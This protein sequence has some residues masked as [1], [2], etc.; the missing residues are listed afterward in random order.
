[1]KNLTN[2]IE[3]TT[4]VKG[5]EICEGVIISSDFKT[6]EALLLFFNKEVSGE[7]AEICYIKRRKGA[8]NWEYWSQTN[9]SYKVYDVI[10]EFGDNYEVIK[11]EDSYSICSNC[12]L[13][14]VDD[15]FE[16]LGSE[17]PENWHINDASGE[18]AVDLSVANEVATFDENGEAMKYSHDVTEWAI[19][20][21]LPTYNEPEE[22]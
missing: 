9:K 22:F 15:L 6:A 5:G 2:L 11:F 14:T 13:R 4:I 8:H 19:A 17:L 10:D 12:S 16:E 18:W 7:G 3:T 21:L 20:V 1:M